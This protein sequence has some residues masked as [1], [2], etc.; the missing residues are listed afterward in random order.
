MPEI[1]TQLPA[2][3]ITSDGKRLSFSAYAFLI[4]LCIAFFIPGIATL[5]P[6]DRDESSFAQASKQMIETGNYT[7]IRLQDKPRYKKPVGIYWLQTASVNLFNPQYLNEIWAY[8]IPSFAGASVAVVMTAALGSLFFGPMAGFLA[9]MMIAGCVILNVEARLAKT[10]AA[11]L[12]SIMVMQ[13]A[14]ARA[15]LNI[16]MNWRVAATFWTA[17]GIG[18]LI[19]GPIILLVLF[20]TLLWLR[21]S[22]KHLRWFNALKPWFGLGYLLLI[23]MPWFVAIALQ[24]H[25]GFMAESAGHDLFAKLWQG[26]DRGILPPGLHLLAFP[27]IFFP[28]AIYVLLAIP[29]V[30]DARKQAAIKFCLGWIIPTWIVFELSLT[31]LPHYTLP[32]YPALAILAAKMLVDGYPVLAEK[33]RWVIAP[34]ITLWLMIGMGFAVAFTL[35]PYL[36]DHSWNIAQIIAA[37][38][39]IIAQGVCLFLL[40]QRKMQ[41]VMVMTF[42]SL[43]FIICVFGNMLPSLQHLWVSRQIVQTAETL[44]ACDDLQIV[45]ASYGEPSLVFMAG[46]NTKLVPDGGTAAGEMKRNPCA[47][48]V[49]D[50]KHKQAFLDSFATNETQPAPMGKVEGLNI[51]HGHAT[52]LTLYLLPQKPFAQ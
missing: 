23:V 39:L 34:A 31:K 5:P 2:A 30:W 50:D 49:V 8:R 4:L 17:L 24:S 36:A 52:V 14:L 32:T 46:T 48:G 22:N 10:D 11:L 12:G 18:I 42:G 47:V 27:I 45:S 9:A 37:L 38:V 26:Q 28:F 40:F 35:L 20:S 43:L 1:T 16:R 19:K 25:G 44:K 41:S 3:F 15:Y 21:L 51:G 29:D 13:Y 6:T 33:G 7:D